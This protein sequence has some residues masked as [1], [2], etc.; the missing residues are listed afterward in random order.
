M[1]RKKLVVLL[2][3]S[4]IMIYSFNS[5]SISLNAVDCSPLSEDHLPFVH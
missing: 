1:K 5:Q 2:I 4:I 3:T